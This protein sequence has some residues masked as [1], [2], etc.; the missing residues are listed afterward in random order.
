MGPKFLKY[1]EDMIFFLP[2][3]LKYQKNLYIF[4]LKMGMTPKNVKCHMV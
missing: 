4:D 1:L 3:P 2:N